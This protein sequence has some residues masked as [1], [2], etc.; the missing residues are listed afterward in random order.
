MIKVLA[1]VMKQVRGCSFQSFKNKT[2]VT[3]SKIFMSILMTLNRFLVSHQCNHDNDKLYLAY[4]LI[5]RTFIYSMKY[6]FSLILINLATA[7]GMP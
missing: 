5:K 7:L 6:V 2:F 4:S 3:F 1:D